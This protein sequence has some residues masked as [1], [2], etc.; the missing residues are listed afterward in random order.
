[1]YESHLTVCRRLGADWAKVADAP[2][3]GRGGKKQAV[4]HGGSLWVVS[5]AQVWRSGNGARWRGR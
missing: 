1:M 4:A 5:G 2:W 3:E